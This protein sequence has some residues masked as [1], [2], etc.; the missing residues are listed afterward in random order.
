MANKG[1]R[2][3]TSRKGK[4]THSK[5]VEKQ[6]RKLPVW[7]IIT[8]LLLVAVFCA[9]YYYYLIY[10]KEDDYVPP[11]GEL[12]FHFLSLGNK[13]NGD[14]I[15]V[16]AGDN[17]ILIDAGSKE[18]SISYIENYL[19]TYVTDNV[20]E[21]VIVTHADSDHIAGFSK[22]SGSIFD[23]FECKTIIDFPL[24]T[25]EKAEK[26]TYNNYISERNDEVAAGAKHYTALQCWNETDGASRVYNL[27]DSVSMEIMYNYYYENLSS[28]ENNHSVCLMFNHGS[29]KFLFTGDLEKSGE[30]K[31]VEY[32]GGTLTQVELFKAGHHGS[33]TSSNDCLLTLIKPK[34]CVVSCCAG[35]NEFGAKPENIFPT[36]SF[37]D[38]ISK[39]TDKVYV[40]RVVADNSDGY[41]NLNGDVKVVSKAD[42]DVFVQASAGEPIILKDT[43]WYKANRTSTYWD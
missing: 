15:Y 16:R 32:Y 42:E 12:E 43:D 13:N 10:Y 3:N 25:T 39:Y 20:L 17:D 8:A 11:V 40:T 29:R 7:V 35:Y 30:E 4:N 34:I 23:L 2:K 14:C 18:N 9:C 38:R 22:R 21:Y 41:E 27:T 31:F 26:T 28:D 19:R 1:K 37:I 6:I 33:K 24:V 5:Q 36:Q